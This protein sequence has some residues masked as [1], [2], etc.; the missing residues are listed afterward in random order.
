MDPSIEANLTKAMKEFTLACIRDA[1]AHAADDLCEFASMVRE[2]KEIDPTQLADS[3]V[4][5]AAAWEKGADDSFGQR[6]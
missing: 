5:I 6:T 2:A 1:I 4:T 3:L